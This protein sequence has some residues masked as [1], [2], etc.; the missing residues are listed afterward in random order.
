MRAKPTRSAWYSLPSRA[1]GPFQAG[2]RRR[3]SAVT[4][5][6]AARV[7]PRRTSSK[8]SSGPDTGRWIGWPSN[9]W[10]QTVPRQWPAVVSLRSYQKRS[11][12]D[13]ASS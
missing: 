7:S 6:G 2:L 11:K 9:C 3:G 1:K 8:A 10:S 5:C 4:A 13:C 12:K